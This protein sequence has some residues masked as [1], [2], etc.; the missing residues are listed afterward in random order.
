MK[1]MFIVINTLHANDRYFG[2]AIRRHHTLEAAQK[3]M[4]KIQRAV[5]RATGRDSYFPLIIVET[6]YDVTKNPMVPRSCA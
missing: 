2:E 4:A 5:K 6:D 3:S 1:T